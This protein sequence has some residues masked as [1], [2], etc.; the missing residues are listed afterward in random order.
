MRYGTFL[1]VTGNFDLPWLSSL[2]PLPEFQ[3]AFLDRF[4]LAIPLPEW[5]SLT[6]Q[7]PGGGLNLTTT[8]NPQ[9]EYFHKKMNFVFLKNNLFW[10]FDVE[11]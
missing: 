6:G 3:G 1:G 11:N 7:I 8:V 5:V 2:V 10:N 9:T 4:P